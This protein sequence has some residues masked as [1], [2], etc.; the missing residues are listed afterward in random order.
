[1]WFT[2]EECKVRFVCSLLVAI[3]STFTTPNL[4]A[5]VVFESVGYQLSEKVWVVIYNFASEKSYSLFCR[6]CHPVYIFGIP[7]ET[8][9]GL[10]RK[11]GG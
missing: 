10:R 4:L 1:M 8:F 5:M 2:K 6:E 9:K 11:Y 7:S 3:W